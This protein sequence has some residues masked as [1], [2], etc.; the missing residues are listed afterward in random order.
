MKRPL[1]IMIIWGYKRKTWLACLL[2]F[3]FMGM[4]G[5]GTWGGRT[6]LKFCWCRRYCFN[7]Q[8]YILSFLTETRSTQAFRIFCGIHMVI[9]KLKQSEYD[10]IHSTY[11][12]Q[13]VVSAIEQVWFFFILVLTLVYQLL[14]ILW[15]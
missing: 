10:K 13:S 7:L 15:L 6:A 1:P 9:R 14:A 8:I 11:Q 4:I 5:N 12:I 2:R 3:R